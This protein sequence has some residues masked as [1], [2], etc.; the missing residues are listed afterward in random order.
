MV[1]G[2]VWAAARAGLA[3]A[4]LVD[5]AWKLERFPARARLPLVRRRW[6]VGDAARVGR[7]VRVV[8]RARGRGARARAWP[9]MRRRRWRRGCCRRSSRIGEAHGAGEPMQRAEAAYE[10]LRSFRFLG[11]LRWRALL[12]SLRDAFALL[13]ARRD[14]DWTIEA[15][16]EQEVEQPILR[17]R[18]ADD[19]AQLATAANATS[20]SGGCGPWPLGRA[21]ARLRYFSA[22][23][24]GAVVEAE[25]ARR[26]LRCAAA[27]RARTAPARRA[28][29]M[30][31]AMARS[32]R[33]AR[34]RFVVQR[35]AR[36]RGAEERLDALGVAGVLARG[37]G[38]EATQRL[39]RASAPARL[40]ARD[41]WRRAAC[42]RTRTAM[43]AS[44]D[45]TIARARGMMPLA[46]RRSTLRSRTS[47]VARAAHRGV[48]RPRLH[49]R[50]PR[51]QHRHLRRQ[52]DRHRLRERPRDVAVRARAS[53]RPHGAVEHG[54]GYR[55][56][57]T[58]VKPGRA[59]RGDR[60]GARVR[61]NASRLGLSLLH[62]PGIRDRDQWIA[63][64]WRQRLEVSVDLLRDRQAAAWD[65]CRSTGHRALE[66]LPIPPFTPQRF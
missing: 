29:G 5:E 52:R 38:V 45:S 44:V 53:V 27:R 31:S 8:R 15:E 48:R 40:L 66:P 28:P 1:R 36:V 46:W 12:S 4:A 50:R 17:L 59:A 39:G 35:V 62:E 63:D 14:V 2:G 34:A 18:R 19:A 54:A 49:R 58:R 56:I 11:G 3:A 47:S 25:R 13:A 37:D 22:P 10:E 51:P 26:D 24:G 7:G 23:A 9:R 57:D 64:W 65:D 16:A 60:G 55:T 30:S 21:N 6:L 33:C 43:T 32:S 20:R 61:E 42:P 41:R